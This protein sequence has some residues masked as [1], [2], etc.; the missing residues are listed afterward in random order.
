MGRHGAE[1]SETGDWTKYS[2]TATTPATRA[3]PKEMSAPSA[4]ALPLS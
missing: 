2:T 1:L 4:I 3:V